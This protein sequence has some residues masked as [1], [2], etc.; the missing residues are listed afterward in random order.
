MY[1]YYSLKLIKISHSWDKYV[2]K[3]NNI[4]VS[5]LPCFETKYSYCI[6]TAVYMYQQISAIFSI[7]KCCICDAVLIFINQIEIVFLFVDEDNIIYCH[8]YNK[9][10]SQKNQKLFHKLL[11]RLPSLFSNHSWIRRFLLLWKKSM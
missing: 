8:R 2:I 5:L 4:G 7:T 6:E 1:I 3:F 9:T 10:H 11:R